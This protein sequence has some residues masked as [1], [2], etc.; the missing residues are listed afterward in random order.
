MRNNGLI[1]L[2]VIALLLAGSF[3]VYGAAADNQTTT[4][5]EDSLN[6]ST[7]E[8][9]SNEM[10]AS[11]E[12]E[13]A[14]VEAVTPTP[15]PTPAIDNN[16][17]PS[18][19]TLSLENH[20]YYPNDVVQLFVYNSTDPAIMVVDPAGISYNVTA[21]RLNDSAYLGEYALN[22]SI[23][24]DNYTVYVMDTLTG[25]S[26]NDTFLVT[27]RPV[28]VTPAPN[29]TVTP[30]PNA[31]ATPSKQLYLYVNTS[32][33]RYLPS[34]LV[35]IT[36][37]TNAGSPTV[38][39]QD[40]VNNTV[41]PVMKSTGNDTYTG[42]YR[43]DKA[44]V[45]GNYTVLAFVNENGTYD[46]TQASFN[47]TVSGGNNSGT[48]PGMK[49]HYAAYDPVQKAIVLRANVTTAS[50]SDTAAV[51]KNDTKVKGMNVKGV[52]V[53]ATNAID[54][55]SK[56]Q[57]VKTEEKNVEV[58][59][60]VDSRN[61]DSVVGQ[62]NLTRD[63]TKATTSVA[64]NANGTN[65]HLSLNDKLDG[66]WYRLSV[67]VPAGYTVSKI[68]RADGI[69][70][71]NDVHVDRATGET[72]GSEINWYVDNGT[73]YFYDDPINGYDITLLPP[74]A[75]TSLS[76]NVVYGGQLSAI[77]Y[78]F[79]QTD[80]DATITAN[81]HLGYEGDNGYAYDIDADAGS[82][83]AVRMYQNNVVNSGKRIMFGNDGY[84]YH[85]YSN[86]PYKYSDVG[87]PVTV[88][89]NTVPDGSVESVI[90]SNYKTTQPTGYNVPSYVNITQKTIIRNN[91]LWFATVYYIKNEGTADISGLR[92]YQGADF[93]FNGQYTRD[94]DFYSSSSDF[95]YGYMDNS[96]PSSIHVGGFRSPLWSSSHDV[97]TYGTVWNRIASDSLLNG[98]STNNID[99][100]MALSW[101]YGTL[102]QG[103]TW[104]VPVIWA[105]GQN[106]TV[107]TSTVNNAVNNYVYD[108]GI[109]SIDSPLNGASLDMVKTPVVTVNAT[110]MDLGVTDQSTTAY[111]LIKNAVGT[112][113]YTSSAPVSM[114]IPYAETAPVSFSWPLTGVAAGTY[115]ISVYT[116]MAG[117]QNRSN[118]LKSVTVYVRDF[119]LYPDQY[120][121]ASPGDNVLYRLDLSNMGATRTFDL[122]ISAS[123]ARWAS[124]LY[125]NNTSVL[126]AS[127]TNGDGTWDSI[128]AA[129][130]DATNNLPAI[131]VPASSTAALLLQKQVPAAADTGILDTVM[132]KAY[133]AG[134]PLV[135]SSA[136][137]RTD[138]PLAPIA[139][140]TFYLHSQTM[141]TS[142]E[143]AS[144]GSKSVTSIFAMWAQTPAFSDSFMITG[145]VSVP[146]Y[147]TTTAAMPITVT[148]FYTDGIGNS[149]LV[150]SNT[151]P[152][153]AATSPAMYNFTIVP[154][155]NVTIP[156]GSYLV[157]KVDNQQTTAF[158]VWYTNAYR[159]RIDVLTPTYV[160][161]SSIDT[162]NGTIPTTS[163]LPGDT[164]YVTGNVADPIGAFDV[165]GATISVNAP[166][167]SLIINNQT[168]ALNRTDSSSPE[169]WK[170]YNYSFGL[171]A[172]M[173][174]GV[175]GINVTGYE[176]NGVISRKNLSITLISSVPALSI[177]P[178]VTTYGAPN[179]YVDMKH[180][181]KN[182]NIYNSD[183]ADI[184]YD[185]TIGW[186][187]SL[188]KND[189][190]T[191][192]TDTD[193]D[194]IPD[195]GSL[196]PL[197]ETEFIVRV[198]VPSGA[199]EGDVDLVNVTARS[200][201]NTAVYAMASDSVTIP[202]SAVL[203]E[204]NATYLG[205]P[206]AVVTF[207]HL[208]TN[209]NVYR[210]DTVG[211]SFTSSAGWPVAL[212]KSDG[213]TLLSDT[214]GDGIPDTGALS[215]QNNTSIIV[216][217]SVPSYVDPGD[218]D[219]I[220][221]TA[222]S[223]LNSSV[224]STATDAVYIS[225]SSVVKTLYLH[226]GSTTNLYMNTS[227]N[228]SAVTQQTIARSVTVTW[229][230]SP[231]FA[232]D[233][234]ILDDPV[235]HVYASSSTSLWSTSSTMSVTLLYTDGTT[236]TTLGTASATVSGSSADEYD[237]D[238]PISGY[239]ITVPAGSKLIVQIKNT[240]NNYNSNQIT[241]YQSSTYPSH[242]DMDTTSY[243][244]VQSV[245]IYNQTGTVITSAT[246][247]T[248]VKVV[249]NVTDPFGSFDISDVSLNMYYPNGTLAVGPLN[250]NLSSTDPAS[251]SMWKIFER[252]VTL[253]TGFD[254][255]TYNFIVTANE[256][257]SVKDNMTAALAV[258]YPVYVR[259]TKSV[260]PNGANNF[261]A[262]LTVTNL[263]SHTVNGVHVYDFYSGLYTAG[264]FSMSRS[265]LPVNNG[266]LSGTINVLGPMTLAPGET[267]T[268]AYSLQGSGN[269]PVSD[270]YVVGVDPYV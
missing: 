60:P 3:S 46:S 50:S 140:K 14:P 107:F 30:S 61:V 262:T 70:I 257:N 210:N 233:F 213:T 95:V 68:V 222:R 215:P 159:S 15:T 76:V 195:T 73:L 133:P 191:P 180:A 230:Q 64:V 104:V 156:R 40:P 135:N 182:L 21:G 174:S 214:D 188:Y 251:P 10:F 99:G 267:R 67:S 249:A 189:G 142:P 51:V 234:N 209:L 33:A 132:L 25:A 241:I 245:T 252:N 218:V 265:A 177:Y 23:I 128:N 158:N 101:D 86:S 201:Q 36:V 184:T 136:V 75:T 204:P 225:T 147:Y 167:G 1:S 208:V 2:I 31:T 113:V 9:S 254:T 247:P 122:N 54:N 202:N 24:L 232:R 149:V 120:V 235:V 28:M 163:F 74:A 34:E 125:Y 231:D 194:G 258:A 17:E 203:I 7:P 236:K 268:I 78:P 196:A 137:L 146:L 205:A 32:K 207:N 20:T 164:V 94:D 47:V 221:V 219:L 154:S 152:L 44:V 183:V 22:Q 123:T 157:L 185:G 166:N 98:T 259:A 171:D 127:D 261:T 117:D 91:N 144:T 77:V 239:N 161:V 57:A 244:D 243:I 162:Y 143:T 114:S 211:I 255:G 200:S 242:I 124:N 138:T 37:T 126:L 212:Y 198:S 66:C 89:F 5:L 155:G 238:I 11:Q 27:T 168:M 150:G 18:P 83:T 62:Y 26:V 103:D 102:Q 81:D 109:S 250:M 97:N 116:Q 141:N 145:N 224:S 206:G 53:L 96:N 71:K 19:L 16:T 43:L 59:I 190:I 80:S 253:G 42:T 223:S 41:R 87:S 269:Y 178:N 226:E 270:M 85:T 112:T 248:T 93:N 199:N 130:L 38:V 13:S 220:D 92:F 39:V 192:F 108:V 56:S 119:S 263:D 240:N 179:S 49:I 129:Y 228:S 82:K 79:N 100:G 88:G 35:D 151:S 170:L 58:I 169:F 115:N 181:V 69:E 121:H 111:L 216:A 84:Y 217:V 55:G 106:A 172:S 148:L 72:V 256:S 110:A 153:S 12:N 173:P 246:P 29:A 186:P 6:N 4:F 176:S 160:H 65:I 165:N 264:G 134:Q 175:Y 139:N 131:S 45:L 52:N 229:M 227:P 260:T 63:I 118:D 197:G 193:G 90:I 187:V 266:I 8:P 48:T 105:V 237:L